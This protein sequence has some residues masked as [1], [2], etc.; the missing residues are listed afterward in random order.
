MR[1]PFFRK[2]E[3]RAYWLA[4]VCAAAVLLRLFYFFATPYDVRG[5]DAPGHVDYVAYVAEKLSLPP[6]DDGFEYYQ[7]PLYYM[8]GAPFVWIARAAN[9]SGETRNFLIQIFSLICSVA[10]FFIGVRMGKKFFPNENQKTSL[11]LYAALLA[12]T[13]SFV[14]FAARVNNDVLFQI[15]SFLSFLLLLAWWKKPSANLWLSICA[16][17]GLGLLTKTSMA[18]MVPLCFLCLAFEKKSGWKE[19]L[20]LGLGG[21]TVILLIAGWFHVPRALDD[22]SKKAVVGNYEALTNFV[23]NDAGNFLTFN[24]I[25][26]LAHPYNDPYDDAA[27]RQEFWEYLYRSAVYGEFHFGDDRMALAFVMLL[28]SLLVL[29]FALWNLVDD[30][31]KRA[32]A[33]LPVWAGFLFLMAGAAAFRF[34][35]PYSSSQDFRYSILLLPIFAYYAVRETG[36]NPLLRHVQIVLAGVFSGASAGFLLTL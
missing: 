28:S 1:I 9:A 27:R 13:P 36:N 24:P 35:F 2:K 33:S 12:A 3:R 10:T 31:R 7:P 18:L 16:V 20:V 19:K 30:M 8:A 32:Y 6:P 23:E 26:V 14:F 4:T 11:A 15:W 29:P 21:M 17:I 25:A 22:G 5:H 34:A